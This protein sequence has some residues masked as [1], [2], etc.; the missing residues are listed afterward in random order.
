ML[1]RY[2]AEQPSDDDYDLKK[3]KRT[4]GSRRPS[5]IKFMETLNGQP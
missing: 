2:T 5:G 4:L 3:Q 1:E